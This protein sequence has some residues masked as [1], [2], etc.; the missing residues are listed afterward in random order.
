MSVCFFV[1]QFW[2]FFC[3]MLYVVAFFWLIPICHYWRLLISQKNTHSVSVKKRTS[4]LK[5]KWPPPT[6]NMWQI[7][8]PSPRRPGEESHPTVL[9]QGRK[10]GSPEKKVPLRKGITSRNHVFWIWGSMSVFKGCGLKK[11]SSESWAWFNIENSFSLIPFEFAFTGVFPGM[12]QYFSKWYGIVDWYPRRKV[13]SVSVGVTW[14]FYID[15][16]VASN[17]HIIIQQEVYHFQQGGWLQGQ[18]TFLPQVLKWHVDDT[19]I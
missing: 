9:T 15:T 17:H 10:A 4:G 14:Y 18:S 7:C 8:W 12:K 3:Y 1:L 6:R 5:V 11:W 16:L 2:A 13:C 19:L